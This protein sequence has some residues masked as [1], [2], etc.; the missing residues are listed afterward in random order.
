MSQ[1]IRKAM[2]DRESQYKPSGLIEMDDSYLGAKN[3]T[4]K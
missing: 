3:T 4:G 2:A 1:K